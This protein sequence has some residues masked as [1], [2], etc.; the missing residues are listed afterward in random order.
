VF[1]DPKDATEEM[2]DE[3][4]DIVN[5]RNKALRLITLAKSAIR[6]NLSHRLDDIKAPTLLVWGMQD[7][8]TPPFVAEQ[9]GELINES[10]VVFIDKCGHAPMMEHPDQFNGVL[11]EFLKEVETEFTEEQV[12]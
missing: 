11:E 7:T 6:E 8:I 9:F 5:D 4:Y 10:R 12:G 1:Y 2:V 3:V